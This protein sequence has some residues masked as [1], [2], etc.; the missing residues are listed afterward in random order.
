MEVA[1]WTAAAVA[2]VAA[3]RWLGKAWQAAQGST[4]NAKLPTL[5]TPQRRL[6]PPRYGELITV[7]SIDGGGIRGLIPTVVL[8]SLEKELKSLEDK[9]EQD[10]ARNDDPRIADYFD[11]IAGTST[12]ALI[13]GMLVTPKDEN[14]ER[15]RTAEEI[16]RVYRDLGPKIFPPM[17]WV[18]KFLRMLW[19]PIYDPKPLHEKIREITGDLRLDQT[20]TTILVPVFDVRRLFPRIVHS[21]KSRGEP[22][23]EDGTGERRAKL[24]DVLIGTTA[25]PFHFPAHYFQEF[26]GRLPHTREELVTRYHVIDGGVGANNPTMAAIMKVASEQ[27]CGENNDFLRLTKVDFTK[28][29][30][31]SIGTGSFKEEETEMYSAKE[32]G[33]WSARQWGFKFRH[34]R[35]PIVD[36][37][38][39]ASNFLVDYNVA[40]L[41]HSHGCEKNYLRIQLMVNPSENTLSMDDAT[42]GNMV[43]LEEFGEN[44]L[45]T[46]LARVSKTTGMYVTVDAETDGGVP[47]NENAL[48]DFAKILYN[49]RRERIRIMR[50]RQDALQA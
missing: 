27:M 17:S 28:Y 6:P 1:A 7:L 16:K 9:G 5:P 15:P 12:G 31:I 35:S 11:V 41:F 46:A 38:T 25:A 40:M 24:S 34:G 49:E 45:N 4:G 21:Y 14:T 44:L 39:Q 50:E 26:L 8:A 13:A 48:R 10:D 37:F 2:A 32:C 22:Q 18:R 20:L 43:K 23:A 33:K 42:P 19:G 3:A 36:V 47:E 30:V 29:H